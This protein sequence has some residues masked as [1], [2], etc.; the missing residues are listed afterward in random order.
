MP[1]TGAD[2][3]SEL[4]SHIVYRLRPMLVNNTSV[5]ED[6][7]QKQ[8][9]AACSLVCRHWS[10]V[11]SSMLFEVITLQSLKDVRFLLDIIDEATCSRP[12]ILDSI[13]IVWFDED[14]RNVSRSPSWLHHAHSL[15]A[16]LPKVSF[17][18]AVYRR[19][20]D[21]R[22]T[23]GSPAVR[24]QAYIYSPFR[25]LPRRP[26]LSILPLTWLS[27]D[28]LQ[29][30]SKIELARFIDSFPTLK[31]CQCQQL[32]FVDPSPVRF[33]RR[34]RR[35]SPSLRNC[36]VVQCDGT[37]LAAQATLASNILMVP[38]H[39]ALDS[40]EWDTI[41]LALIAAAPRS[42][43][44]ASMTLHS[45]DALGTLFPL[46][47]DTW[48]LI[49]Y[50]VLALVTVRFAQGPS[51]TNGDDVMFARAYACWP[52]VTTTDLQPQ[53]AFV[54]CIV[55]WLSFAAEDDV[56]SIKF[57]ALQ[58]IV[59]SPQL[60]ELVLTYDDGPTHPNE[61]KT[62]KTI[63][64]SVLDRKQLTLALKSHKLQFEGPGENEIIR[65]KDIL[66]VP[67]KYTDGAI[68]IVLDTAQQAEWLLCFTQ[69]ERDA[70]LQDLVNEQKTANLWWS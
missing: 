9:L 21:D 26:P 22:V 66:S 58:V 14:I 11:I 51:Y 55:L 3:P 70:Y 27:L 47:R 10:N 56:E 34:Q 39:L 18:Y 49:S 29:F 33:R 59:D 46:L 65:S 50:F 7:R 45:G 15:P 37:A 60:S 13:Q 68:T 62:L 2:L 6:R 19:W 57:D 30:A 54:E 43:D 5:G 67:T 53:S 23:G 36:S 28:Q 17:R 16:R 35:P 61:Y 42:F 38:A 20:D 52:D 31:K 69:D 40:D 1:V 44:K 48:N 41:L 4:L 32:T 64:C 8:G 24:V 63:L 12:F 25:F